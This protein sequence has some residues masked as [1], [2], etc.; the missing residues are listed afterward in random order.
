MVQDREDRGRTLD[1][2][3]PA[4]PMDRS[5]PPGKCP[6]VDPASHP[7]TTTQLVCLFLGV[8]AAGLLCFGVIHATAEGVGSQGSLP[9]APAVLPSGR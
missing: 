2:R 1:R 3:R 7:L 5:A 4:W 8:V 9:E 6:A